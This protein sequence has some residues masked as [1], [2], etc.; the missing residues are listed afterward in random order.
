MDWRTLAIGTCLR[1]VDMTRWTTSR[2]GAAILVLAACTP[3]RSDVT[4][5]GIGV[6]GDAPAGSNDAPGDVIASPSDATGWPGDAATS[7][8]DAGNDVPLADSACG[9]SGRPRDAASAPTM[10]DPDDPS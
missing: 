10:P 5:A 2:A 8:S 9:D 3:T 1:S 6:S 7:S 4:D